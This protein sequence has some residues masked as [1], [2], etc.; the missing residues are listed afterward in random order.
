MLTAGHNFNDGN[1]RNSSDLHGSD[2]NEGSVYSGDFDGA[3]LCC[4]VG[5][6][7]SVV[8]QEMGSSC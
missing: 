7:H 5:T 8:A 6:V 3:S 4:G 2:E 1:L